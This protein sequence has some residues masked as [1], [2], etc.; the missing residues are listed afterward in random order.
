VFKA[1]DAPWHVHQ[2]G[3]DSSQLWA[4]MICERCVIEWTIDEL[5]TE[6]EK[7]RAA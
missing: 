3:V 4:D 2:S 5:K 1:L 7:A 6:F